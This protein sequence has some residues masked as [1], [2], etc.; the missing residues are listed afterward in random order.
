[1]RVRAGFTLMELLVVIAIAASLMAVTLP[2]MSRSLAEVRLQRA[3]TVVSSDLRLA[4][5]LA[6][7]QRRPVTIAIDTAAR[8]FRV[9]DTQVATR[10]F[11]ERRLDS[12]SDYPLHR[13][14]ASSLSIVVFPNGLASDSLNMTMTANGITRTIRMTRAG[15]VRIQ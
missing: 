4:H 7:R 9:R 3:A 1:M 5:S 13:M 12:R 10:I 14:Q 6:E 2:K 15:Q 8:I 11:A